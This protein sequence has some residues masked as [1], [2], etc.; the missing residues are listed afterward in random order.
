MTTAASD[1]TPPESP[2]APPGAAGD[3]S[4][5]L[6]L[7][8][9]L[10]ETTALPL[11][12]DPEKLQFIGECFDATYASE[13]A[14][15]G[16]SVTLSPSM[17]AI[18]GSR[19]N[20]KRT[21][22]STRSDVREFSD[23]S[24][25]RLL[26]TA[27]TLDFS[28]VN[29]HPIF[30]TLTYPR[31]WRSVCPSGRTAKAHLLAFRKQYERRWGP[32]QAVWKMETQPRPTRP[33]EERHAPH[34]H[35]FM[36]YPEVDPNT[37]SPMDILDFQT[38]TSRSWYEIV[39]SKELDHLK[40]G[41]QVQHLRADS[42]SAAVTYFAGYFAPGKG[43]NKDDQHI[44][45]D[46][47]TGVGRFWGI[48]G[49]P[50]IELKFDLTYEEFV[51]LRRVLRRL[52]RQRDSRPPLSARQRRKRIRSYQPGRRDPQGLWLLTQAD[53]TL[54]V[55]L[56]TWIRPESRDLLALSIDADTGKDL[57][58]NKEQTCAVFP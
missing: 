10:P 3:F 44:L 20:S 34:F 14:P 58:N 52:M 24:R 25:R 29:G 9:N 32:I 18:S 56:L 45:A 37:N 55:R 57:T 28:K 27:A 12:S 39:G 30:V 31:D 21:T 54:I 13:D 7:F 4:L 35:L 43:K 40:A 6:S 1:Q 22:P 46:G 16:H 48:W 11:T 41:T 33:E 49:I 19:T 51:L 8:H 38:W 2:A 47:W 50:R 17:I 42:P 53:Q 23:A 15:S 36:T 5:G 26:K